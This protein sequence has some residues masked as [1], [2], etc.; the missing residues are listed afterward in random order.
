MFRVYNPGDSCKERRE[1]KKEEES[2]TRE[3]ASKRQRGRE[4]LKY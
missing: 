2:I 3:R 4:S 1:K